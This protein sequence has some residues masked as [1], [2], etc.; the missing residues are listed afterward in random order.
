MKK[1][2]SVRVNENIAVIGLNAGYMIADGTIVPENS[3]S[4]H[5]EIVRLAYEFEETYSDEQL[6]EGYLEI[7]DEFA[8]KKIL[9][10]YGIEN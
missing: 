10:F 5:N 2:E 4:L 1:S 6:D 8:R 7:I 9:E 3:T